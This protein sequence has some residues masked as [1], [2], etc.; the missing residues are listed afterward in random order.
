MCQSLTASARK[1]T[2]WAAILGL[3]VA[4]PAVAS[5]AQPTSQPRPRPPEPLTEAR[6]L[7]NE[8]RFD[9]SL[10]IARA[11]AD[12]PNTRP[13]ALLLVGRAA[14]E[15]YRLTGEQPDLDLARESLRTVDASRLDPRERVEFAIGL[16]ETLFFEQAH[17]AAA[18]MFQGILDHEAAFGSG[19]RDRLLDWWAGAIDRLAQAKPAAERGTLYDSL[20]ARMVQ[21]LRRD[22]TLAAPNYWIPAALLAKGDADAAWDAAMAG[23][24][25]AQMAAWGTSE[26]RADIDVLVQQAIVP[27]RARKVGRTDADVE[28]ATNALLA[29]WAAFKDRWR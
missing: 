25:R 21:E 15:R 11:A 6:R 22:L 1:A 10:A 20:V 17:G 2:R 13:G 12:V 5:H 3:L 18:E 24:L 28:A 8:G 14:L 29:D 4:L 19:S 26:A 9:D 23:W 16:G 27:E 7:Y